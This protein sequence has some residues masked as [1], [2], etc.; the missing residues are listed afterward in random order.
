MS[1]GPFRRPLPGAFF[2]YV[3]FPEFRFAS[4]RAL[5][6]RTLR[7]LLGHPPRERNSAGGAK[8]YSPGVARSGTPGKPI[9]KI[10]APGG[11]TEI[12]SSKIAFIKRQ[13]MRAQHNLELLE[14]RNRSMMFFLSLDVTA[15]LRHL[16]LTHREGTVSFL[17]RES[18][19]ILEGP[20]NPAR[21]VCFHLTDG[22]RDC[23]VLPQL[24]QDMNMIGRSVDDQRDSLFIAN[25]PAEVL[26][27]AR[28]N[29]RRQPWFAFL[30][31]KNNMIEQVAMGGTHSAGPF[32]R[33][34]SGAALFLNHTPGVPLRS[35]PDFN[36]AHPPGAVEM[37]PISVRA[38]RPS[39]PE[40]RGNKARSE[41]KQTPGTLHDIGKPLVR[42]GGER[43][44]AE[45]RI[46]AGQL[47]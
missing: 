31:R 16:R 25:G 33:P 15:H 10:R 14:E 40:A 39:A 12:R 27:N 11:A 2:V 18:R 35:T 20:R 26:M 1:T 23:F 9:Q 4:L 29:S 34:T 13:R 7:A 24:R 5:I 45:R 21:R 44:W 17:P 37:I 32:R 42:G 6:W 22:F 46:S 38:Q 8:E 3:C 47:K 41:A 28:T 19:D 30:G 36:P 43:V